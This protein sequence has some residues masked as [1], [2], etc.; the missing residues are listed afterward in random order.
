MW[1]ESQRWNEDSHCD[2]RR[3]GNRWVVRPGGDTVTRAEQ[4]Y[5]LGRVR[6]VAFSPDGQSIL[7]GAAANKSMRTG[8]SVKIASLVKGLPP[9]CLPKM[10]QW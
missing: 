5:G 3:H 2:C 8:Q 4:V 6:S 10:K 7:I 1:D 9:A